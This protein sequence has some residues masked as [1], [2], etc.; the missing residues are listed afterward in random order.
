[1]VVSD[2]N[3]KGLFIIKPKVYSDERGLFFESWNKKEFKKKTGIKKD[4][5]QDNFSRS[6]RGVLRGL[7]Y[8]I[9]HPQAK[10]V[11]V[12]RGEALDV[13]VDL[14]K[15]SLTYGK[16]FSIILNENNNL[17][18]YIP[19]GMAHGFYARTDIVDFMYKTT[20]YYCNDCERTIIWNDPYLGI[21]WNLLNSKPTLSTKDQKLA[22]PF[23]ESEK[24]N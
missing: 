14:R 23:L 3:M 6:H 19:E 7:H 17:K 9:H 16:Y 24:F 12:I 8:Q 1:M 21:D 20:D 18:L 5:V 4:F 11:S 10:L 13:V 15:S 22:T 2:T